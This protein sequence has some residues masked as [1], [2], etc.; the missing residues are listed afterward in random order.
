MQ[1]IQPIALDEAPPRKRTPVAPLEWA[2]EQRGGRFRLLLAGCGKS[3]DVLEKLDAPCTGLLLRDGQELEVYN[4]TAE[5]V[6]QFFGSLTG[7]Q[8]RVSNG[9]GKK[10]GAIEV[11]PTKRTRKVS[12][13]VRHAR[14]ERM[15]RLN[16]SKGA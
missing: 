11:Q 16:Q 8:T 6:A 4:L 12:E 7:K 9:R 2:I 1:D 13:A 5:Q 14:S 15:R 10:A 3:W